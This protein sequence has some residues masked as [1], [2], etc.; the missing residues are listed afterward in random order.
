[1][2]GVFGVVFAYCSTPDPFKTIQYAVNNFES[3]NMQSEKINSDRPPKNEKGRLSKRTTKTYFP[4][5]F[6]SRGNNDT[7]EL[8][9][10]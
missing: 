5:G 10:S 7:P 1:M 2:L 3:N 8:F 6:V 9:Q 4:L